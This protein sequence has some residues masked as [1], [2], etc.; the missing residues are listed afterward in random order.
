VRTERE[1]LAT[2]D[3]DGK[4][5]GMPFMPEMTRFFGQTFRVGRRVVKTCVE[6]NAIRRL[7][8]TVLLEGLRCDGAFHEGCQRN[9]LYFWKDAWL[10]PVEAGDEGSR[11]PGPVLAPKAAA[12]WTE[13][14]PTRSDERFICQS[15]ELLGATQALSRWDLT[16]LL[17]EI[18]V[19]E[20]SIP[21]FLQILA[22]TLAN[23]VRELFG[24]KRLGQLTG[25]RENFT[26][27]DLN[28]KPGEWVEIKPAQEIR[29][30]LDGEG[31]N[32]GLSFEPT[33]MDFTEGRFQVDFPIQRIISERTGLMV[34]LVHTVALKGV[35]CTGLCAKNCPRNNTLY[36]REAWLRRIEQ[37]P[38]Q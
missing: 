15:T 2:L 30:T 21:L 5:E 33:M 34:P 28:L 6:G 22:H 4:L 24:L 32:R 13:R 16:H 19:G 27:G 36:W 17:T 7:T 11:D 18:R 29:R 31:R 1:I 35:N 14:F 20:L 38:G 23:R 8:A 37:E 10:E 25:T 12:G 9:C 26:K 3:A